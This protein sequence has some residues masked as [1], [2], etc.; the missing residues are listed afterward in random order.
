MREVESSGSTA[1]IDALGRDL[2]R[3]ST[4]GGVQVGERGSRAPGSVKSSAGT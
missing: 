1:R 3:D 2:S 4:V